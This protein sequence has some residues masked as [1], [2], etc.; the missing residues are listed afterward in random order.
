MSPR[1]HQKSAVPTGLPVSSPFP[2]R[3]EVRGYTHGVPTGLFPLS[4]FQPRTQVRGYIRSVPTG[5]KDGLMA[6]RRIAVFSAT[7]LALSGCA[8]TGGR[9]ATP[10]AALRRRSV[11]ALKAGL[12][13]AANPAVRALSVEALRWCPDE[14]AMPW[15]RTALLDD[16]PAVRF[17]ACVAIGERKDQGGMGGVRQRVGDSDA[18]VRVAAL[19]ALHRLGDESQTQRIPVYLLENPDAAVRRNAAMLLGLMGEK[20]AVKVL[21]GAMKDRDPGVRHYAL[22]ALARLGNAEAKQELTFMANSGVGADETFAVQALA[23]SGD[24]RVEDTLRYKLQ[25]APHLETKL[26]AA[27]GLALL[28]RSDGYQLALTSL[29]LMRATVHDP[30]DD[31]QGQV[32]RVRLLAAA[33]VG[34]MGNT[35]ALPALGG[36]LEKS[37]DPRVQIAA[38]QAIL[39]ILD[40]R[41]G[42]LRAGN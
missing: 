19:F 32:L 12:G 24:P 15:V 2:P 1:W 23:G 26:A 8:T 4:R 9:G 30:E 39:R 31:P 11:D 25:A 16:H 40:A 7:L 22:E 33:A 27:R 42:R 28:G 17:A 29:T 21:A 3:T 6:I 41:R 5:R 13:Y 20:S 14:Q 38:A 10:D 37:S 18:G 36:M 34:A 35:D